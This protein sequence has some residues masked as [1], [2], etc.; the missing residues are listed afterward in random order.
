MTTGADRGKLN[1][2]RVQDSDLIGIDGT[3]GINWTYIDCDIWDADGVGIRPGKYGEIRGGSFVAA[4]NAGSLDKIGAGVLAAY[5]SGGASALTITA[6]GD[7]S[8]VSGSRVNFGISVQ[9][10]AVKAAITTTEVPTI[11]DN[12]TGTITDNNIQ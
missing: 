10:G 5:F 4:G 9:T 1:G 2:V 11:T 3:L 6:G 7:S 8:R 12:G